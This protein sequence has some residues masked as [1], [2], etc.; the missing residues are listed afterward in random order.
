MQEL[1]L[2]RSDL[3]FLAPEG[4]AVGAG[5]QRQ[6]AHLHRVVDDL[7]R[8]AAQHGADARQQL[9][10]R[11]RLGDVVV[12]ARVETLHL[13]RLVAARGEHQDRD[14]LGALVLAPLA[15][16]RSAALAGQ[17]PVEQDDVGQHR[18]D[19][20]LCRRT[21]K[22]D[23]GRK[24]VVAQVDGDQLGDRRFVFHHQNTWQFSHD[25]NP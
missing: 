11:K 12:G 23:R 9:L 13:V 15:C 20:A 10:R 18:V 5:V 7:G 16:Q 21:V 2:G 19:L 17:H 4:D 6:F 8:T 3:E 14:R 1:E 25:S 24:A 22:N